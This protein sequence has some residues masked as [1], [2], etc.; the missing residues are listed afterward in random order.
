MSSPHNSLAQRNAR[1]AGQPS[2]GNGQAIS[3]QPSIS[4][5]ACWLPAEPDR[6]QIATANAV[7]SLRISSPASWQAGD[8]ARRPREL[9]NMQ[10]GGGAIDDIDIA[11]LVGFDI[12]GL[13]RHLAAVLALAGDAALVGRCRDRGNEIADFGP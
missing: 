7:S 1:P 8:G 3:R 11:A 13:D 5:R 12:V 2:R 9:K 6:V 10:A 4:D